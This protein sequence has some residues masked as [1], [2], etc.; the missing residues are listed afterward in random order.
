MQM[1]HYWQFLDT[2]NPFRNGKL[3]CGN[4]HGISPAYKFLKNAVWHHLK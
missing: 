2:L 1:S 4:P 3:T